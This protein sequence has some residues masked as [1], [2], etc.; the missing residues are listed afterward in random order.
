PN[1]KRTTLP[2]LI[3]ASIAGC[4]LYL[5]TL[6]APFQFDDFESI[7]NN[8]RLYDINNFIPP[9][10]S[11]DVGSL[12]FALNFAL[13]RYDVVSY[14][15]FN[16]LI[17]ILNSILVFFLYG[18]LLN[19]ISPET[20]K[21]K[22]KTPSPSPLP[23][24]QAGSPPRGD[25]ASAFGTPSLK[26]TPPGSASPP[27]KIRGGKGGGMISGGGEGDVCGFTNYGIGK[28]SLIAGFTAL[29]FLVH[30]IQTG[31]VTYIVQRFASLATLFYLF[32]IVMF[33]KSSVR[34]SAEK[35][36]FSATH[37]TYYL[38][39][40]LSAVLA[41]RTKEIALTLPLA[42]LICWILISTA[43]ENSRTWAA[44]I[45]YVMPFLIAFF[46]IPLGFLNTSLPIGELIGEIGSKSTAAKDIRRTEYLFTQFRV[47]ATYLRLMF[48]PIGQNLD[49]DYRI[50]KSLFEPTVL[51]SLSLH[52]AIIVSAIIY[53][54]RN[55]RGLSVIIF[56]GIFWFYLTLSVESSF[57]PIK[58][59]IFEHRLYLPSSGLIA[60]FV[61][62]FVISAEKFKKE[63]IYT[64][65]LT[66]MI[67]VL[68]ML[69][70]LTIKRNMLWQ[71]GIA[72]WEDTIRKSPHKSRPY[73]NLGNIYNERRRYKDAETVYLK[74]IEIDPEFPG[75]YNNLGNTYKAGHR[76]KEAIDEYAKALNLDPRYAEAY[77]N[78]GTALY[79][80]GRNE[81]ALA[82]YKKALEL[83]PQMFEAYTA[84]GN[85]YDDMGLKTAALEMYARSIE[86]NP[87]YFMTYYNR[88]VL[89]ETMRDI[90]NARKD[91]LKALELN[92]DSDLPKRRLEII[93][94]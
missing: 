65:I 57:I 11:R 23:T 56:F 76:Y 45:L 50:S 63:K 69:S 41:M 21:D 27:L 8:T 14:H 30:P 47:I 51:M 58:D 85:S 3:I 6:N 20:S 37:L 7:V 74:A 71:D 83:S 40:L 4:L 75:I 12:T 28:N 31:A 60:A 25:N 13:S 19:K 5:N 62:V 42:I 22:H 54:L 66:V 53:F 33:L 29:I 88:G 79:D 18:L 44:K 9:T 90:E 77:Y 80:M 17:H 92:P 1:W 73:S 24:G 86:I 81:E 91:Y 55:R 36:F 46:I 43:R 2:F 48:V 64:I 87:Y 49:Y 39:S 67:P 38:L 59:V 35:R 34:Y 89:C 15:I 78:L 61:T 70:G 84:I 32:S 10:G 72:L 82:N 68:V 16:I 26:I 94:W 93:G 52:I